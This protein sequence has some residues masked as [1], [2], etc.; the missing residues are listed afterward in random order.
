MSSQGD[1]VLS[2]PR[3]LTVKDL[4]NNLAKVQDC[5]SD[6]AGR[7]QAKR[8]DPEAITRFP[9][10]NLLVHT[11]M[12]HYE[13]FHRHY[14]GWLKEKCHEKKEEQR[15]AKLRG[16]FEGK[17]VV[18]KKKM[19]ELFREASHD[20]LSSYTLFLTKVS[21]GMPPETDDPFTKFA[22][23]VKPGEYQNLTS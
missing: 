12:H 3:P 1:E 2:S 20:E 13:S 21:Q 14:E 5:L 19:E 8:E 4:M 22:N 17:N 16:I 18:V 23:K 6:V 9:E 15:C 11:C 7:L 10:K